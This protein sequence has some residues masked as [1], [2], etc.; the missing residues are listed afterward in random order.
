MSK[1]LIVDD[2]SENVYLLDIIL[3]EEG[4]DTVSAANGKEALEQ[5]RSSFPDLIISDIFMPVMDGFTFLRECKLDENLKNIP[6]VFYTATYTDPKD[7]QFA[8]DQGVDLILVKP[9]DPFEVVKSIRMLLER[10]GGMDLPSLKAEP[11]PD[12]EFLKG[13]SETVVRKLE[14][15]VQE[16]DEANRALFTSERKFHRI[17][18]D[19]I[20]GIFQSTPEGRYTMV[21]PALA[22][23]FGYDSPQEMIDAVAD[24]GRELY[25][26]PRD[27]ERARSLLAEKGLLL[28]FIAPFRHRSGRTIWLSLNSHAVRREDGTVEYFEG[29]AEDITEKM[30]WEGLY[31]SL[32]DRSFTGIYLLQDGQFQFLNRS[33]AAF[34]GYTPEELVGKDSLYC[35]HPDDREKARTLT[36]RMIR[37]GMAVPFEV[38]II[39]KDGTVRWIMLTLNLTEYRGRPAILGNSL[40][41]TEWKETREKLDYSKTM[42]ASILNSI[43]LAVIGLENRRIVFANDDTTRVFGWQP[44]ELYGRSARILYRSEEEFQR[45]GNEVYQAL[46]IQE[47][48]TVEMEALCRH[49]DGKDIF[50]RMK[51]ARIGER[52]Q[53]N[54]IVATYED[55]TEL[56]E[57]KERLGQT[58]EQLQN[59]LS[60]TIRTIS[61]LLEAKDPYTAGHQ[62]RVNRLV[63]A[64]AREMHL[65]EEH[66]QFLGT[67]ALL[68]DVGKIHIPSDIL[69]KPGKLSDVEYRLIQI[70]PEEGYEIIRHIDFAYP[71]AEV[72]FQ[73]HERLD[74]SGYPRGLSGDRILQGARIIAVA[75]VVEAMSSHRPYRPS[76]G[77]DVALDEIT[78]HRGTRYDAGVVDACRRLLLEKGFRFENDH[79]ANQ[80]AEPPSSTL[81][82]PASGPQREGK[83]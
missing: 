73:H 15:K 31:K 6:F 79:A 80:P 44:E 72:I 1:I 75:D 45:I 53:D 28:G 36:R 76:L 10:R 82:R 57:T 77:V 19:S 67:A 60:G 46:G 48:I 22:R 55:I 83:G 3:R 68:H 59:T 56:V 37:E 26:D 81:G 32:T 12:D 34:A 30:E 74:G 63:T 8:L 61:S 62:E 78:M 25:L 66:V 23:M 47:N 2:T 52:L 14:E 35:I 40:D 39:C 27:R 51:A 18:E 42:E 71:I 4:F 13:Y 11:P 64:I 65:P 21:N 5:A 20:L 43:P 41:I 33:A 69:S 17:F 54:R 50:C 9:V 29:T 16:L 7:R 58:F 49:M 70:H 38:R 24:I